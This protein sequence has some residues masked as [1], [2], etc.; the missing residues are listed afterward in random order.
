LKDNWIFS[1]RRVKG[2]IGKLFNSMII[3]KYETYG[4][5]CVFCMKSC[6]LHIPF[7]YFTPHKCEIILQI[8]GI[9]SIQ[10]RAT[11]SDRQGA[12]SSRGIHPRAIS[13]RGIHPRAISSRGIHPRAISSRGI[14]PR[15]ISSRGIHPRAISSRGIHPR[16]ISHEEYIHEQSVTRNTSTS[17][18]FT[19]NTST[20][21][22]SRGIH[23]RAISS[24]SRD[25][26][27]VRPPPLYAMEYIHGNIHGNIHM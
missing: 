16:A 8:V 22:Q 11:T 6:F 12:I 21:D 17:N 27:P 13:S 10:E 3:N 24:P 4:E 20:S 7:S 2:K 9:I 26:P 19:R 14:H 18:Q 1:L 5:G 23:P 15:A 25:V